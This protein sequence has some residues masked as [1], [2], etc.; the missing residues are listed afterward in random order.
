MPRPALAPSP[1]LERRLAKRRPHRR[2][3]LALVV[4]M[5]AAGVSGWWWL[6]PRTST[7]SAE[8]GT[9]Y[10]VVAPRTYQ[11]TVPAPGTLRAAASAEVRTERAG[12][13]AWSAGLGAR[14]TAGDVVARLDPTDLERE[15][16]DA[17]LALARSERSLTATRSDQADAERT[18][19]N[20]VEDVE[21]RLERAREAAVAAHAELDLTRR[22]A[23]IGSVAPRDLA[24]AEAVAA[25]ADEEAVTAQ[26]T[27]AGAR[28]DLVAR[29][30]RADRDLADASASVEQARVT[31][32]RAQHALASAEL[33]APFDGVVDEVRIGARAYAG[34]N[35]AV[36]VVSDDHRLELVAEVDETEIGLIALGQRASVTVV[37]QGD[38]NVPAEVVAVAPSARTSQNIPVFEIVLAIANADGALRPGMTG[39]AEVVVR[40]EDDTVTLPS[41]ALKRLPGTG[42]VVTA[43]DAAGAAYPVPVELIATIG[44]SVVV[45]GALPAGTEVEVPA[46]GAAPVAASREAPREGLFPGGAV[47]GGAVPGLPSGTGNPGGFGGG[48]ARP[49]GGGQ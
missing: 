36:V 22:L 42:A 45:R 20:A 38:R 25:T 26:R 4:T 30:A 49:G 16:R 17:E 32:E 5:A 35:A 47:P 31:L 39:E 41:S 46:A 7:A 6:G 21:R 29:Q 24:D 27:L 44:T 9:S 2:L 43:R 14:V 15:L 8:A 19:A 10:V 34:S 3:A 28:A 12:T 11:V 37:A 23:V 48:G 33:R 40:S 18:L 13:I 1:A